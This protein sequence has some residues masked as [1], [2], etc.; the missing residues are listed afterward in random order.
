MFMMVSVVNTKLL[1]SSTWISQ[2]LSGLVE[3]KAN[4]I[5][6]GAKDWY[7]RASEVRVLNSLLLGFLGT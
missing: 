3:G 6:F 5:S 2:R 4:L 1:S 7:N